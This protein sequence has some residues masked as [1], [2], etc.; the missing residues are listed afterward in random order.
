MDCVIIINLSSITIIII[1]LHSL[2]IPYTKTPW[3]AYLQYT[4]LI[5]IWAYRIFDN[6]FNGNIQLH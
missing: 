3:S 2:F 5:D 6:I 4:T 1:R